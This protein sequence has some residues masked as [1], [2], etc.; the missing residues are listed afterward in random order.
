MLKAEKQEEQVP[1]PNCT[2]ATNASRLGGSLISSQ[3]H[4]AMWSLIRVA[5]RQ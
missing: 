3:H 5:V 1:A 4:K 2:P